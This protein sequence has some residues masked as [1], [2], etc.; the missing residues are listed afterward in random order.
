M[1][2]FLDI[3]TYFFNTSSPDTQFIYD[4]SLACPAELMS[5]LFA[6]E[7]MW[8]FFFFF[9]IGLPSSLDSKPGHKYVTFGEEGVP[10]NSDMRQVI[11]GNYVREHKVACRT[12]ALLCW[13]RAGKMTSWVD[14]AFLLAWG[15]SRTLGTGIWL[16]AGRWKNLG[17]IFG[18][19]SRD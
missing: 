1:T 14:T 13:W 8:S 9:G 16:E 7:G 6:A 19:S 15:L 11:Y 12:V 5:F 18:R 4:N 17:S 10:R 3:S 2:Q